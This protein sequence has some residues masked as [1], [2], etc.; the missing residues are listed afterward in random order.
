MPT[1]VTYYLFLSGTDVIERLQLLKIS[2]PHSFRLKKSKGVTQSKYINV[3]P[4]YGTKLKIH[5][6][7]IKLLIIT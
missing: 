5:R 1:Q 6:T 2:F 3:K 7:T 4:S